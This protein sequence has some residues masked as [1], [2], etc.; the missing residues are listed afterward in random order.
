MN[1][2]LPTFTHSPQQALFLVSLRQGLKKLEIGSD[3]R[4]TVTYPSGHFCRTTIVRTFLAEVEDK[5]RVSFLAEN[6][7]IAKNMV[8]PEMSY[9]SYRELVARLSESHT[10][11]V[12]AGSEGPEFDL[13][14]KIIEE[15]NM[16]CLFIRR[17]RSGPR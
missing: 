17:D 3:I 1:Q 6:P 4:H 13:F 14:C 12:D 2:N 15:L 16:K 8:P 11:V 7:R 10:V 5:R 9:G